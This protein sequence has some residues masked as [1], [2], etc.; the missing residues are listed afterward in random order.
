MTH[1]W[2]YQFTFSADRLKRAV[3]SKQQDRF[4]H[5]WQKSKEENQSKMTFYAT[6]TQDLTYRT[7]LYLLVNTKHQ[8]RKDLPRLRIER[9]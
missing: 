7:E 8:C 2:D 9:T 3:L 1:V 5:F 6:M 4:N